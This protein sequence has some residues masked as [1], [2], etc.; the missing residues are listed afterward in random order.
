MTIPYTWSV[1]EGGGD[2]PFVF[3]NASPQAGSTATIRLIALGA[4]V[5]ITWDGTTLTIP[6]GGG[7]AIGDA[8]GNSPIVNAVLFADGSGN[9]AQSTGLTFAA[10]NLNVGDPTNV[11]PAVDISPAALYV[12]D[13]SFAE[14][15]LIESAGITVLGDSGVVVKSQFPALLLT[16]PDSEAWGLEGGSEDSGKSIDLAFSGV[17]GATAFV[18]NRNGTMKLPSLAGTGTRTVVADANGVLSAP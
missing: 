9:L 18:A 14:Y 2:A 6:G 12:S 1:Y 16:F 17:G 8:I 11:G 7:I 3:E 4:P 13:N 10:G 5:D 15:V